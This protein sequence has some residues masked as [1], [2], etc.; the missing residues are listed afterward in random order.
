MDKV[1]CTEEQDTCHLSSSNVDSTNLIKL[2]LRF[3]HLSRET[4]MPSPPP[5]YSYTLINVPQSD[6]TTLHLLDTKLQK[7]RHYIQD[8]G[9]CEPWDTIGS[10]VQDS[11]EDSWACRN[12]DA[13]QGMSLRLNFNLTLP[14]CSGWSGWK[15][16][17]RKWRILE[18]IDA[19][20]GA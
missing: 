13:E 6:T 2:P 17:G 1:E 18:E 10:G 5:C 15:K 12:L 20:S 11:S 4:I 9:V 16:P 3:P 14:Q 7:H 19:G 8:V